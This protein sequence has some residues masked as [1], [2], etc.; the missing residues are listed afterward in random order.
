MDKSTFINR[1][2]KIQNATMQLDK[3]SDVMG[4]DFWETPM[5]DAIYIAV[6]ILA[7]MCKIENDFA[8]ERFFDAFWSATE[9]KSDI[10]VWETF[11][12][13]LVKEKQ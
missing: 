1:V 2:I 6:E 7:E 9:K 3:I 11:Y 5:A 13:E 10:S 12:D 4:V 8:M